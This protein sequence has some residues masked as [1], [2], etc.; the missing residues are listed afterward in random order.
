LIRDIGSR[1]LLTYSAVHLLAHNLQMLAAAVINT[2]E[3][4][5]T[6]FELL[7]CSR[8]VTLLIER[9]LFGQLP[10]DGL[11]NVVDLATRKRK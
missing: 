11:A 3:S 1:R 5:E 10:P 8:D 6:A 2:G 4:P 7:N 9:R